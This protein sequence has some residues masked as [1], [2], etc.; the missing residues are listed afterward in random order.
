MFL[1]LLNTCI[2]SQQLG[3]NLD[4]FFSPTDYYFLEMFLRAR[5]ETKKGI[6]KQNLVIYE[7]L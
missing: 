6:L 4:H 5:Q 2:F 1:E 3:A 7:I